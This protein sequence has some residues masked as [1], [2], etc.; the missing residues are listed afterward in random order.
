MR[1]KALR[2]DNK[3]YKEFEKVSEGYEFPLFVMYRNMLGGHKNYITFETLFCTQQS[4]NK[5]IP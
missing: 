3:M 1:M 2:R 4:C 5:A